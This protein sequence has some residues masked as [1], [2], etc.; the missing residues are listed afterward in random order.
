[1]VFCV[2]CFCLLDAAH[3]V[4]CSRDGYGRQRFRAFL[5]TVLQ[6]VEPSSASDPIGPSGSS[7]S[8][9]SRKG[10]VRAL[11]EL[12]EKEIFMKEAALA[13]LAEDGLSAAAAAA[14]AAASSS[15]S[16][17]VAE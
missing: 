16:R 7:S 11:A 13:P 1:L 14:A 17:V 2:Y 15:S 10:D 4:A 9:S 6:E 12:I 5:S 3:V 8:S